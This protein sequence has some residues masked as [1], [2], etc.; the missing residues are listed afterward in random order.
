MKYIRDEHQIFVSLR[1]GDDV[2]GSLTEV[3]ERESLRSGLILGI[4]AVR[5]V[6]LGYYD[7]EKQDYCR[8]RFSG[9]FELLGF[10]GNISFRDELL[11]I[12]PHVTLS[13]ENFK[14]IGGHLFEGVISAA[15]EFV[16]LPG[17]LKISRK[18]D[19]DIKLPLWHF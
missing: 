14:V 3:A 17:S 11:F 18:P 15:G 10:T 8:R 12:H 13:G 16:I 6:V 1:P 5:D 9:S 7:L 19:P 4:G 2:V